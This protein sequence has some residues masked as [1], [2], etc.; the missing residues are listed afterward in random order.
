MQSPQQHDILLVSANGKLV[1]PFCGRSTH[2][3]VLPTTV[4]KDFPLYCKFCRRESIV[5]VNMSQSH[6]ASAE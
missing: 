1:C 6:C 4:L 2:Q 5:N 3:P